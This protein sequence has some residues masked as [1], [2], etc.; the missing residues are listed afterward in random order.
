MSP[1][2]RLSG[3]HVP[4]VGL[5]FELPRQRLLLVKAQRVLDGEARGAELPEIVEEHRHVEVGAPF[6]RARILFERRDGIVDV[7]EAVDLAV[8]LLQRL[9]QI[10][11]L[12]VTLER[13]DRALR[14]FRN[15]QRGG[16]LKLEDRNAGI[17]QF[18]QRLGDVLVFHRLVAD[19]VDDAEMPPQRLVR[20][21]DRHA[22]QLR[23]FLDR[24]A[25][26][27][28]FGEVVDRLVGGF[29]KAERLGLERELH[30]AAGAVS[31]FDQMRDDAKHV[32]GVARD[33]M[34]VRDPRLE[35]ERRALDRRRDMFGTRHRPA[36]RRH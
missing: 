22:R 8:L 15:V 23:E 18:L 14:H 30:R 3:Q 31:Q 17:D 10:D 24:G 12:G 36:P 25:G 32:I 13:I 27:K 11:G 26:I 16:F 35:P 33:H 1:V 4:G 29:E 7:E 34:A 20:I 5:D 19:V 6:A 9:R 21:G 2:F 28:V